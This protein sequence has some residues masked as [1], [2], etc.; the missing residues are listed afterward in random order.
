MATSRDSQRV[1]NASQHLQ[2]SLLAHSIMTVHSYQRSRH[3][4]KCGSFGLEAAVVSNTTEDCR[5]TQFM[6][7]MSFCSVSAELSRHTEFLIVQQPL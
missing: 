2:N 1:Q 7:H 3:F 4:Q 6:T 5:G